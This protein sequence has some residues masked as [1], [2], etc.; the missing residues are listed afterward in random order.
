MQ[1]QTPLN[2]FQDPPGPWPHPKSPW[3]S[4]HGSETVSIPDHDHARQWH[5]PTSLELQPGERIAYSLR[6][7][8]ADSGPASRD[9]LLL[10]T[11]RPALHG[12]PGF[13]L[14]KEMDARLLV[15][16]PAGLTLA[17]ATSTAPGVLGVA[18]PEPVTPVPAV[19]PTTAI[20]HDPHLIEEQLPPHLPRKSQPKAF[21]V[22]IIVKGPGRARVELRFSD[23]SIGSAHYLVVPAPSLQDR[24]IAPHSKALALTG[25]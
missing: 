21:S 5:K 25:R 1:R 15:E 7:A 14:S 24:C 22:P 19:A 20:A 10:R 13:V 8:L 2:S 23:G 6:F 11:G 18:K 4:W 16:V 9:A 17:S 12:V 3:P